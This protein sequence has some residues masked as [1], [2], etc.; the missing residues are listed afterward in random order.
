[1]RPLSISDPEYGHHDHEIQSF[2]NFL[3]QTDDFW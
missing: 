1:M 3:S 2:G